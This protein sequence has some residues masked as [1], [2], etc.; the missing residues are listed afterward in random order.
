MTRVN[1]DQALKRIILEAYYNMYTS[2][3]E[4]Y[5]LQYANRS[6]LEI[7]VDLKTIHGSIN[8]IQPNSQ[9]TSTI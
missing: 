9:R 1:V 4:D 8:P 5:L 6:A 2:Q 7:L 3:L